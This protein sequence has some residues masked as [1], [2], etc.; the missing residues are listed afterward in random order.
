MQCLILLHSPTIIDMK[1]LQT[2]IDEADNDIDNDTDDEDYYKVGFNGEDD[3]WSSVVVVVT[4]CLF[5]V[6][7]RQLTWKCSLPTNALAPTVMFAR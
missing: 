7:E 6:T 3:H 4:G 5:T 1:N 2:A